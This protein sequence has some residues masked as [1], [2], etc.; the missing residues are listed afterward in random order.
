[1]ALKRTIVATLV[2][3]PFQIMLINLLLILALGAGAGRL[4]VESGIDIFF[5]ENDPNLLAEHQLKRTYGREDNILFVIDAGDG[6]IFDAQ[7]LA[8]LEAITQQ[9]W[10]MPHSKRVD[11][12]TNYLYPEVD[13]DDIRIDPLV[14]DTTTLSAADIEHIRSVALSQQ[15]LAGRLLAQDGRVAAINVH[16]N[17]PEEQKAAAIA[18]SAQFAREISREAMQRNPGID[19]HLAGWAMNEQTLAE[20]TAH[21]GRTLMPALFA[22]VLVILALLLRSVLASLCTVVA[23][24]LSILTGMGFAGWSG[25]GLN[26]VNVSAPTIIMTLAIADCIHVLTAFLVHYRAELDKRAAL[27]AGLEDTLYPVT[28][29][30]ITTALG[31]LTMNFSESPPFRELGTISAVG[32]LGALW[33]TLA[34]LPGLILLLPFK[35][36]KG[37]NTGIELNGL[38]NFVI[39]HHNRI[40]WSSLLL[41]VLAISFIPKIELN[42]DPAGYFA[43]SVPLSQSI[44]I[45]ENKLSGTQTLHYSFDSGKD[46][47][48]A[49]PLFLSRVDEFV[50]WLRA[51]PEVVNVESFTD[52]LKRLNQ[53]MHEDNEAWHKLPDSKEMAAQYVLLY[54][55]SI[56]YGQDVTHQLSASKS[57]LKVSAIL[58]NQKSQGLLAFEERSQR[59]LQE[60][61]P[62][63]S[64]LGTGQSISF[65][66]VG[67]RNIDSMLLGSLVAILLIS[68]CLVLAFRSVKLGLVSFVPNLFPAL[69]TLGIW[70]A[71]VGEVNIAVSV[72]FSLTLGIIVDDTTHFL[73]KYIEGRRHRGLGTDAAM[74]Y[75]FNTVGKAL[76]STSIVLAIGFLALVQ[77]AFSVNSTSGLLVAITIIVA[78]VLDLLFLPTVLIKADKLLFRAESSSVK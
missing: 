67:L 32:V 55:I 38:A 21:D 61:T 1:M 16:L 56:P 69:I 72:V 71:I 40:F 3:Y 78:I 6:D 52:T 73:V 43:E 62:E 46:Q 54:E 10:Q 39:R 70:G 42:D 50:V 5:S 24:L 53:V 64:A 25:I 29:T 17:L 60:N 63:I 47:G 48:I 65:A 74:R 49:D 19:I 2:R 20:V 7:N 41:I 44:D 66:N 30:S 18:R 14:E 77:S 22:I 59:W 68:A 23:I 31:F 35:A 26:S 28:L 34:I 12:V 4:F 33:V 27:A 51:Q 37:T 57:S 8:S 9:S 75:T 11:S 36:K 58:K 13:G 15:A 76:V 45:L